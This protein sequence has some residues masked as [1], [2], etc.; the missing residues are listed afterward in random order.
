MS[1]SSAR[2]GVEAT[3]INPDRAAANSAA[4]PHQSRMRRIDTI[5][6]SLGC[7][8]G[9][10]ERTI[11]RYSE[12][13]PPGESSPGP[14]YRSPVTR[15]GGSDLTAQPLPALP[16]RQP[17][18]ESEQP[19]DNPPPSAIAQGRLLPPRARANGTLR[20]LQEA[21]LVRF[22]EQG[23]HGVSIRELAEAAG[24]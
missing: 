19:I 1:C 3:R 16:A 11:A 23:Y 12:S 20:R 13:D 5:S 21:A 15:G 6:S 17:G 7:A 22:G 14:R 2:P 18:V 10:A 9:L 24:V 8:P 4:A